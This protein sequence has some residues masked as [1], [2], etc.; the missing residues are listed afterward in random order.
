MAK[1]YRGTKSRIV[2][3]LYGSLFLALGIGLFSIV[4]LPD[5]QGSP[6]A[7]L[8]VVILGLLVVFGLFNIGK[9]VFQSEYRIIVNIHRGELDLRFGKRIFR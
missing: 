9:A 4:G 3:V 1:V 5:G 7:L 2:G 8:P 6:E